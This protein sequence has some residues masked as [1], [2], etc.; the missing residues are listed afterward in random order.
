M[1]KEVQEVDKNCEQRR[2]RRAS[3]PRDE[4]GVGSEGRGAGGVLYGWTRSERM[5]LIRSR[6]D[7]QTKIN[8]VRIEIRLF[9]LGM[10]Q[11]YYHTLT[12]TYARQ[13]IDTRPYESQNQHQ[14][15]ARAAE[16]FSMRA[17]VLN[18]PPIII[19]DGWSLDWVFL[20]VRHALSLAYVCIPR[21]D[22]L[23]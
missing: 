17:T 7:C 21:P 11:Y 13:I 8:I 23:T 9:C 5:H 18:P 6:R 1:N 12:H 14:Q 19:E 16:K 3:K 20:S 15:K 4:R 2:R 10:C 22:S